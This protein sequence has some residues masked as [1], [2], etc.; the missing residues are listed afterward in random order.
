MYLLDTNV[1]SEAVRPRPD[2]NVEQWLRQVDSV[3][4]FTAAIVVSELLF[5]V[6]S[7]PNPARAAAVSKVV[8]QGLSDL[9]GGRVLP[10]D[11][12]AARVH[13]RLRVATRGRNRP[14]YD[15]QIAATALA[16]DMIMVTRNTADFEDLGLV[17]L[18]PWLA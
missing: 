5:G 10:F 4:T 17:L 3:R 8:E 16:N 1:I 18:N 14:I 6:L 11:D 7:H 12:N 2:Q 9:I 13:A 15:L